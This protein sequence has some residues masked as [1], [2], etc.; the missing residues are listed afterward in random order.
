MRRTATPRLACC[1]VRGGQVVP[2]WARAPRFRVLDHG[3]VGFLLYRHETVGISN[4]IM[5]IPR[6]IVTMSLTSHCEELALATVLVLTVDGAVHRGV[7]LRP[8]Q[9][10]L[11]V[12]ALAAQRSTVSTADCRAVS[13]GGDGFALRRVS[14]R[15]RCVVLAALCAR[16][17]CARCACAYS[18]LKPCAVPVDWA[19]STLMSILM[20]HKSELDFM[21][22]I[23]AFIQRRT[24]YFH[25]ENP[26]ATRNFDSL[27]QVLSF[28]RD[29]LSNP[30]PPA[31]APAPKAKAKAKS[32]PKPK[33]NPP[34]PAAAAPTV[35]APAPAPPPESTDATAAASAAESADDAAKPKLVGNGGATDN[36][37]WVQTLGDL[38]VSVP[39]PEGATQPFFARSPPPALM[40]VVALCI[41]MRACCLLVDC[42]PG[43]RAR[44]LDVRITGTRLVVGLKGSPPIVDGD[45]H[46]P[47]KSAEEHSY[48]TLEDNKEVTLFLQK[49]CIAFPWR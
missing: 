13:A 10:R 42:F 14:H 29:Q 47:I 12:R 48:W 15:A 4:Y 39:V 19:C 5:Q 34:A 11:G 45:F 28:Q 18:V 6:F 8:R 31:P 33:A 26:E 1:L 38:T 2:W 23:F 44:Q 7:A 49:V 36:Y 40:E 22:T 3:H 41:C 46:K 32:K 43:T 16:C 35:P 30:Q 24:K 20:Q 27:I 37:R 9:A 21:N 25:P 17:A